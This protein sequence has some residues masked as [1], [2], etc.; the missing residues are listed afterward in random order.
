MG[1]ELPRVQVYFVDGAPA[2]AFFPGAPS[3]EFCPFVV[4]GRHV[5]NDFPKNVVVMKSD[6]RY[7]EDIIRHGE[8]RE[9]YIDGL[10]SLD[11]PMALVQVQCQVSGHRA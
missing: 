10:N 8:P 2:S 4:R 6:E 5:L 11:Q 9:I 3:E 1:S 7:A